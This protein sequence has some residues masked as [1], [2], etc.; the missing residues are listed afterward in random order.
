MKTKV[1]FRKEAKE[2]FQSICCKIQDISP[3]KYPM[4]KIARSL[5]LQIVW[6]QPEESRRRFTGVCEAFLNAKRIKT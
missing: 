3:L 1:N 6:T 4:K 2:I 5:S